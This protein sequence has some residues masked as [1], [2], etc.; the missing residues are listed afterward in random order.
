MLQTRLFCTSAALLHP[1]NVLHSTAQHTS[2]ATIRETSFNVSVIERKMLYCWRFIFY[3]ASTRQW[4]QWH[5]CT[6]NSI[7]HSH[8]GC[9]IRNQ[10]NFTW[11]KRF[12]TRRLSSVNWKEWRLI[13][14]NKY[15]K[16]VQRRDSKS[17]RPIEANWS[18]LAI[19]NRMV[20]FN[21]RQQTPFQNDLKHTQ[22][23]KKKEK[24]FANV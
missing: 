5:L 10:I 14:W 23:V 1:E 16:T 17:Y 6:P 7:Y 9:C 18:V 22:K 24:S 4:I 15:M 13:D 3:N 21:K 8:S 19:S 11:M 2:S 20:N 12:K